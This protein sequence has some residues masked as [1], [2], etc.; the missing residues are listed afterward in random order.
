M[1]N[2]KDEFNRAFE[3]TIK[4]GFSITN[5]ITN[6]KVFS[7]GSSI[8]KLQDLFQETMMQTIQSNMI[9][10]RLNYLKINHEETYEKLPKNK[11]DNNYYYI[12]LYNNCLNIHLLVLTLIEKYFDVNAYLT[13]GY[14]SEEIIR[15]KCF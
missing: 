11:S 10:T 1:Y 6:R 4:L 2:Y 9:E 8:E 3:S 12:A 13:L 15:N 14:Y 7:N 5:I